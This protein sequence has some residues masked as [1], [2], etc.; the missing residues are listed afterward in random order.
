MN[1]IVLTAIVNHRVSTEAREA[2]GQ[3]ITLS[4]ATGALR[5]ISATLFCC[6]SYRYSTRFALFRRS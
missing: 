6:E 1:L 3:P 5:S 4:A 2:K